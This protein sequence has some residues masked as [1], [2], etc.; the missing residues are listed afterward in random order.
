VSGDDTLPNVYANALLELTFEQGVAQEVLAEL[1]AL[2]QVLEANPNFRTFLHTPHIEQEV[3]KGVVE[4]VFGGQLS[5]ITHNF[6]RVVID[7]RRQLYLER[8]IEAFEAGYHVRMDELVVRVTS[9]TPLQKSQRDKLHS[10]LKSKFKK[11]VYLEEKVN[12]RLL[13]GLVLR[14]GDDR[15]DGSLRSRLET[16][17]SRLAGV[18]FG[19]EDYYED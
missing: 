17:G 11:E 2:R 6:V 15:I 8:I 13:G 5:D 7:K 3:K 9:A 1:R 19:S 4:R 10:V 12:E 16:I 18:R 14:V